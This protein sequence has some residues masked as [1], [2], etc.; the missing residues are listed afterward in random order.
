MSHLLTL[1]NNFD[2]IL[3]W[4]FGN[5]QKRYKAIEIFLINFYRSGHRF[6]WFKMSGRCTL[7]TYPKM[8]KIGLV[9]LKI[10]RHLSKIKMAS[11][12]G[13]HNTDFHHLQICCRGDDSAHLEYLEVPRCSLWIFKSYP[14]LLIP[15]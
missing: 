5:C 13:I 12:L 4:G 8:S 9:D 7:L 2:Q 11:Y 6:F 14:S 15:P 1:I 10:F 3:F